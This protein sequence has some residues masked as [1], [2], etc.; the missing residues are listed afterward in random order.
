MGPRPSATSSSSAPRVDAS[1]APSLPART[2]ITGGTG[3]TILSEA[4]RR[5]EISDRDMRRKRPPV[6]SLLMRMGTAIR[7]ARVVSLMALDFAGVSLAIFTALVLKAVVFD[8]VQLTPALHETALELPYRL[9]LSPNS[10]A[11]WRHDV[12]P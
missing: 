6:L 2:A 11:A 5:R 4:N 12:D 1:A 9:V 7:V 8:R 3:G 10:E